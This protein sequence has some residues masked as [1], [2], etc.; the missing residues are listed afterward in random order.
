MEK[1][2]N[3]YKDFMFESLEDKFKDKIS[4]N[5]TLKRGILLLLDDSVEDTDN[6]VN[7][8]N[9]INDYIEDDEKVALVGLIDD[10]DIFDFWNKYKTEVD[11]I[12][13][14]VDFFDKSPNENNIFSIYDFMTQGTKIAV[15]E[16]MKSLENDLFSEKTTQTQDEE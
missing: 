6:L 14:G 9:F 13:K 2:T 1:F 5:E 12:L 8:Q 3:K 11:E 7:V 15:Q 10:A 16:A 4:D